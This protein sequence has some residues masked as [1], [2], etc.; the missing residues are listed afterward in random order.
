M[1][2]PFEALLQQEVN[3]IQSNEDAI[4]LM[5]GLPIEDIK[6]L[7]Q[8]LIQKNDTQ[9]NR[10][11]ALKSI[12]INKIIPDDVFMFHILSYLPLLLPSCKVNQVNKHWATMCDDW[13]KIHY[14]KLKNAFETQDKISGNI[15][16]KNLNNTWIMYDDADL[17]KICSKTISKEI[18]QDLNLKIFEKGISQVKDGDRIIL[19]P[20]VYEIKEKGGQCIWN[21][22]HNV[23]II[24]VYTKTILKVC[25]YTCDAVFL[26][27]K[28]SY[29]HTKKLNVYIKNIQYQGIRMISFCKT[30]SSTNLTIDNCYIDYKYYGIIMNRYASSLTVNNT[31]FHGNGPCIKMNVF[32]QCSLNIAN[33]NCLVNYGLIHRVNEFTEK[34]ESFVIG[35]TTDFDISFIGRVNGGCISIWKLPHDE[36]EIDSESD[37]KIYCQ[38]NKFQSYIYPIGTKTMNHIT[39]DASHKFKDNEWN[40]YK[41]KIISNFCR[42]SMCSSSK[43]GLSKCLLP[44]DNILSDH[45][46]CDGCS[47][48]VH[49]ECLYQEDPK[50]CYMCYFM[51]SQKSITYNNNKCDGITVSKILPKSTILDN[52]CQH[53][54][55]QMEVGHF[56]YGDDAQCDKCSERF[57]DDSTRWH[58]GDIVHDI[59]YPPY[60]GR[61]K[62]HCHMTICQQCLIQFIDDD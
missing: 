62:W 2:L 11:L 54:F 29:K 15:F 61:T 28:Y 8:E 52:I 19:Y 32:G 22:Q 36:H 12:S 43:C 34:R 50:L 48:K 27:G 25:G 35:P 45:T 47:D 9:L 46:V 40:Y 5:I 13:I 6:Q 33:C 49:P 26:L 60:H 3:N 42:D 18:Q 20:G 57:D 17:N 41:P 55:V 24:G 10:L 1:S 30:A 16:D 58:C 4:P 53:E 59:S 14:N 44:T 31:T 23:S 7:L 21:I 37:L 39:I 51:E 56:L 38:G